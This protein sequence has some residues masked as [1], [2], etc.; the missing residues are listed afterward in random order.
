MFEQAPN[1]AVEMAEARRWVSQGIDA[2]KTLRSIRLQ[3][4]FSQ[5]ALAV[6]VGLQQ[7]NICAIE[8]GKRRPEYETAQRLAR[9]MNVSVDEIYLAFNQGETK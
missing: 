9:A 1:G 5:A 2:R 7:P 3:A 4:G 8:T 6:A